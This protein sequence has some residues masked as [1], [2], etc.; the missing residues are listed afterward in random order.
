MDREPARDAVLHRGAF[1]VIAK[2]VDPT[3][4]VAGIQIALWQAR[5][6]AGALPKKRSAFN[7]QCRLVPDISLSICGGASQAPDKTK[8]VI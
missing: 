7:A 4:T 6:L 5:L 2:P 1:D 3:E 8:P